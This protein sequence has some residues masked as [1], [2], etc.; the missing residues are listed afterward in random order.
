MELLVSNEFLMPTAV[1]SAVCHELYDN[2][3]NLKSQSDAFCA[4]GLVVMGLLLWEEG[5]GK[6]DLRTV[7]R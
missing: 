1:S 2:P 7:V 3:V 6:Q 5:S 4:L